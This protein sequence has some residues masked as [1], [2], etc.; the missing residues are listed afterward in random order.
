[1]T[2]YATPLLGGKWSAKVTEKGKTLASCMHRHG[3]VAAALECA[4]EMRS[5]IERRR[6][7]EGR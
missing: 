3:S 6:K 2:R 4:T 5:R 7:A 1:M